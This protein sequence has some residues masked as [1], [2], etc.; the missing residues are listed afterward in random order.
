[1]IGKIAQ[2]ILGAVGMLTATYGAA[3]FWVQQGAIS[4]REIWP[5]PAL[6]LIEWALL[7]LAGFWG[8]SFG[9]SSGRGN[10][11][12]WFASGALLPMGI[13]GGFS[14][15]P[16]VLLSLLPLLAAALIAAVRT[17]FRLLSGLGW[18]GIGAL[19]NLLFML[20]LIMLS[21]PSF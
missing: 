21:N 1:M 13:L 2:W 3:V 15:G 9:S 11:T 7:G 10:K 18:F 12:A 16:L 19:A 4:G 20:L 5:L 6:V 17:K 14:I 8:V